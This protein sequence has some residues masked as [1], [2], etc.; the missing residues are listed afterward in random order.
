MWVL[1]DKD[2]DEIISDLDLYDHPIVEELRLVGKCAGCVG[3]N[4]QR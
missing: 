3:Y 2:I 1:V 4:P